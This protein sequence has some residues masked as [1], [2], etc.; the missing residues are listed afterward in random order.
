MKFILPIILIVIAIGSFLAV[1]NPMYKSVGLLRADMA[2]Y[3]E[4]LA[5]ATALRSV[6]DRLNETYSSFSPSDL[7]KLEKMLPDTVDNIRLVLEINTIAN[8]HQLSL[9]NIKYDVAQ[10]DADVAANSRTKAPAKPYKAFEIAFSTEGTYENFLLFLKD[11][12]K[13]LRIIDIGNI[14]FSVVDGQSGTVPTGVYRYDFKI[15]TYWLQ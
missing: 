14:S 2:S 4:A 9:K 13:N 10:K 7:A 6:R 8:Q 1:T 12:E 5:N 3:N 15:K 11:V